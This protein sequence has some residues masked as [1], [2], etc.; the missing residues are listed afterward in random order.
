MRVIA[1][2]TDSQARLSSGRAPRLARWVFGMCLAV[3]PPVFAEDLSS[4]RQRWER[5]SIA[6]YELRYRRVC[7]CHPDQT[8]D[9]IVTV[10]RGGVTAVR[11]ARED[12]IEDI[13]VPAEQ[14]Q[15]FRAVDD[16][17]SLIETASSRRALVRASFDQEYG[18]PAAIFIDYD[19]D[20]VGDEVDIRV[21][22]F[23]PE[24]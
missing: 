1:F 18:Y 10:R 23:L 15:W 8:A 21:T 11:Y 4:A 7:D 17:F 2:S 16:F 14:L 24:R 22:A 13:P 12:Y 6:D 3:V 19:L 9:T 5:A 20:L